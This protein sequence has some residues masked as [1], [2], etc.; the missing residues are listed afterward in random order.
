VV[1]RDPAAFARLYP[2]RTALATPDG[3]GGSL[4]NSRETVT[5]SQ[6]VPVMDTA[7]PL[8][9]V[10]VTNNTVVER[11]TYR[12]G[13]EWHALADGG[14]SS[15]ERIDP[16]ADPALARSWAASDESQKSAWTTLEFTGRI[17]HGF[18]ASANGDPNE[19]HIGLMD[20]GECLI[21]AVEVRATGGANLVNNPSFESDTPDWRFMGT[22]DRSSIEPVAGAFDGQRALR[23]RASDRVHTG[24]NVI[25]GAMSATLPKSGTGTIRAR[26]RWLSGC[27]E[28][29]IR[30][31][32]NWLEASG[33]ILT[34]R[35][36]GSPG[37]PN[38]R[39]ANAA[40]AIYDVI[41]QP[42]LPRTGEK[43]TVYA[44]L[45]D[46]DGLAQ[47]HLV[48]RVQGQAVT[49]RVAM[50]PCAAGFLA[51][52]IPAGCPPARWSLS[53][54]AE[55]CGVPAARRPLSGRRPGPRMSGGFSEPLDSRAFGIYRF[56]MTQENID[57]W[58]RRERAS[59][60]PVDATFIYGNDRV[61]NTRHESPAPV[62]Q[63]LLVADRH[64]APSITRRSFRT[65]T[66]CSTTTAWCSRLSATSATMTS[67]S[68]SSSAS[69]W[70]RRSG[71]RTSTAASCMS[72][73][74]APSSSAKRF[75]RT[76][77]SPTP[78]SSSTGSRR[79]TTTTSSRSTTGSSTRSTSRPSR[80]SPR[81]C[82]RI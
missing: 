40:P 63:Q 82:S 10:V 13:G 76:P 29:L 34:T 48:Y 15:L 60:A 27:P 35:A 20:A 80:S 57:Y 26:V 71:C 56:W 4:A 69:R 18:T 44:R 3:F 81:A 68:A 62:P 74:T 12:D 16:R 33:P 7:D 17:D 49:N 8:A 42:V 67:A 25:R 70:C 58:T 32:G 77:R 6:P 45:H 75:T 28:L 54:R 5:L 78:A 72:T 9:P 64:T 41:H 47:A 30:T 1:P 39:A 38:S 46:P 50:R 55:D 59:N 19:M 51:A 21:D 2:D 43:V 65:T 14:G 24:M 31:R 66:P 53:H 23:L 79:T 11:V 73:P 61:L 22:H 52:E 37:Q 36:L